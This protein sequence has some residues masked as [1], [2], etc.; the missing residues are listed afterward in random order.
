MNNR[1]HVYRVCR[2]V[3][4]AVISVAISTVLAESFLAGHPASHGGPSLTRVC[5]DG[6]IHFCLVLPPEAPSS[7][8]PVSSSSSPDE[9]HA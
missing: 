3:S 9:E 5:S 6:R 4:L 8:M 2:L 7:L 1:L